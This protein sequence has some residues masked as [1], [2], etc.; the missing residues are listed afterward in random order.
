MYLFA[1]LCGVPLFSDTRRRPPTRMKSTQFCSYTALP[2]CFKQN[3]METAHQ[4]SGESNSIHRKHPSVSIAK[5]Q[6]FGNS[7]VP[8]GLHV[9]SGPLNRMQPH[10]R[11]LRL[12]RFCT[13]QYMNIFRIRLGFSEPKYY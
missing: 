1:V 12:M 4:L 3:E 2:T 13:P 11:H 5:F 8:S 6:V 9:P 7:L 10:L